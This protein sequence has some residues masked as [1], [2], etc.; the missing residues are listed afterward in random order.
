MN[1]DG[2]TGLEAA[3]GHRNLSFMAVPVVGMLCPVGL[4]AKTISSPAISLFVDFVS[5]LSDLVDRPFIEEKV[6]QPIHFAFHQHCY[7][8]ITTTS[9]EQ[10]HLKILH[11]RP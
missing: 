11:L 9:S 4:Y 8:A 1:S 5:N 7:Q 6:E 2:N 3:D 10:Q